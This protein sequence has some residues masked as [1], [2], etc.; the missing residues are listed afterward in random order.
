MMDYESFIV[1][2]CD[3][4]DSLNYRNVSKEWNDNFSDVNLTRSMKCWTRINAE[5]KLPVIWRSRIVASVNWDRINHISFNLPSRCVGTF[6]LHKQ[7]K[8]TKSLCIELTFQDG[9]QWNLTQL[10]RI[11]DAWKMDHLG[12]QLHILAHHPNEYHIYKELSTPSVNMW[13]NGPATHCPICWDG[14]VNTRCGRCQK[15][16]CDDCKLICPTHGEYCGYCVG[17]MDYCEQSLQC[18]TNPK[19]FTCPQCRSIQECARCNKS[20]CSSA[21]TWRLSS[22][23]QHD[24][25]KWM[26]GF[27]PYRGPLKVCCTCISEID[28]EK[29]DPCGFYWGN[30]TNVVV[31]TLTII[32]FIFLFATSSQFRQNFFGLF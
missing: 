19:D 27:P 3:L 22:R 18:K 11:I 13:N 9:I 31:A 12:T 23:Q 15:Y 28:T 8:N 5:R 26:I 2:F 20:L 29:C 7:G 16:V 10:S 1:P 4:H 30:L 14:T 25:I 24:K 21:S 6:L 17:P 32:L